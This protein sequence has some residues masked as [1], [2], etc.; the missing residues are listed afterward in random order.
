MKKLM[1]LSLTAILISLSSLFQGLQGQSEID[2]IFVYEDHLGNEYFSIPKDSMAIID[3]W[4]RKGIEGK[5]AQLAT[6]KLMEQIRLG[7]IFADSIAL[8]TQLDLISAQSEIN[9][10]TEENY[11]LRRNS[12]YCEETIDKLDEINKQAK[13]DVK[14]YK[15]KLFWRNVLDVVIGIFLGF[16]IYFVVI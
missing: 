15:R 1:L 4:A 5:Q 16:F 12:K 10:L 7:K 3:W 8:T 11:V 14:K 9:K 6:E 2:H 13:K